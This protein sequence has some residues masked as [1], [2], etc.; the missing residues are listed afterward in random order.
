[1]NIYQKINDKEK[2]LVRYQEEK[3]HYQMTNFNEHINVDNFEVHL[4]HLDENNKTTI[5]K[6]INK[7]KVV[8]AKNKFD[9]GR[10]KHAEAQIKLIQDRYISKKPYRYSIPDQKEIESQI[11]N[12]LNAGLIEETNT[13]F[14]AP[15]TLVYKKDGCRYRLCVNFRKLNKLVIPEP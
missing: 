13:P 6:L 15:V 12:L 7:Y 9:V 4:Q 11:T 8:F 5:I 2:E 14:A 10:V 1:M 3:E